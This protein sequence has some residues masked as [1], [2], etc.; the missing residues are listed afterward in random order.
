MPLTEPLKELVATA[1]LLLNEW[2]KFVVA[3][4]PLLAAA[5]P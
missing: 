4:L 2:L 1:V 5:V 3:V